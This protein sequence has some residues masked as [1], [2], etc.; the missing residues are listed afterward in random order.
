MK[1]ILLIIAFC[2]SLFSASIFTLENVNNLKLYFANNSDF[3]TPKQTVFIKKST[4][5]K[6]KVAG[7][8]LNKVD[9][10]TFMIKV[11]SIEVDESYAVVISIALGEEVITNRKERI[12]SFAW[13]YYKTDIIDTDEPYTD[14]LESIN[15]LVDEFVESYLD[16]ME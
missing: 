5:E 10:S 3:I 6:L 14:T 4:E 12:E 2:S 11:E 15:Y 1:K 13:S 8:E 7:I 16:D 9:A